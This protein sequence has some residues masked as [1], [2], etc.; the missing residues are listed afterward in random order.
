VVL[1]PYR[2]QAYV[3]VAGLALSQTPALATD[4]QQPVS[5]A[6]VQPLMNKDWEGIPGKELTALVFLSPWCERRSIPLTLDA[7]GDVRRISGHAAQDAMTPRAAVI[8][9]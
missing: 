5:P 3:A 4:A 2:R 6:I 7:S 8:G 1:L 9:P